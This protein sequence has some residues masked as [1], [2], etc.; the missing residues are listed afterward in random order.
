MTRIY[1][2]LR[3]LS[4]PDLDG[5][6]VGHSGRAAFET[7]VRARR[8]LTTSMITPV[9]T[10]FSRVYVAQ[11]GG[12]KADNTV[13]L[14][15]EAGGYRRLTLQDLTLGYQPRVPLSRLDKTL[16]AI[17]EDYPVGSPTRQLADALGEVLDLWAL[18][19]REG[20]AAVPLQQI[21]QVIGDRLRPLFP[22][23]SPDD[24]PGGP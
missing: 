6:L 15:L 3:I 16:A 22:A 10:R 4:G 7:V 9:L 1:A 11:V 23:W 14:A 13:D 24:E 12:N 21:D 20:T 5:V 2:R 19:R 17:A 8:G 18:H